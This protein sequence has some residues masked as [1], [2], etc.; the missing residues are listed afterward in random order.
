[1]DSAEL[2][3]NLQIHRRIVV[4]ILAA[5]ILLVTFRLG[6]RLAVYLEFYKDMSGYAVVEVIEVDPTENNK[7]GK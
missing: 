7:G 5:A 6:F 2:L 4:I 1:M 3:G